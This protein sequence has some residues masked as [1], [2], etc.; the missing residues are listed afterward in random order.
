MT[1][2]RDGF[3]L[4]YSKNFPPHVESQACGLS[5][6]NIPSQILMDIEEYEALD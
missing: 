5:C 1:T 2:S 6:C 3:F 4:V